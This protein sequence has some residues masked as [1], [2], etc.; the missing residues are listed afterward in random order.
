MLQLQKDMNI[1]EPFI[2]E[3]G[4]ALY[5]PLN[6][7]KKHNISDND[8]S[9]L[10]DRENLNLLQDEKFYRNSIWP[11]QRCYCSSCLLPAARN[12]P[13]SFQGTQIGLFEELM[14][15]TGLN[16]DNAELSMSRLY[17]EPIDLG[18]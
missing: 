12:R 8:L 16:K 9:E 14:S 17:S 2:V 15:H 18:R 10:M 11:T 1:D 13:I 4:S 3:N 5:L 7:F 6:F